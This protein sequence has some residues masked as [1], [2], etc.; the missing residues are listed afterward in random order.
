MREVSQ[1]R[2]R[3]FVAMPAGTA[4]PQFP[5][6][7]RSRTPTSLTRLR[8]EASVC[9]RCRLYKR[10]TQTVFG[11]GS[12][13]SELMLVGEQPG[14]VEDRAGR[15]F[16]G[17]AGTLLR[18]VLEEVGIAADDTYVTNA[19]KHFKWRPVG[20][21]RIHDK[22]NWTE[23]RAC[24]HWLELELA[25]VSPELVVCLGATAAQALFGRSARVGAMRGRPH[26][27]T[28]TTRALVTIHPSAVLRA[29]EA[30]HERR[31][32][33]RAD[34]RLAATLLER[35]RQISNTTKS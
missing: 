17:P 5:T 29:G 27:L 7:A 18:D 12:P 33:L 3:R 35:R 10:A 24:G 26:D 16:V 20:K 34:L 15:P 1:P 11:E 32:E 22:P 9:T 28:A 13:R 4:A 31:A 19:V 2:P 21:R 14:D 6:M 8:A 25:A 30:R 23:I